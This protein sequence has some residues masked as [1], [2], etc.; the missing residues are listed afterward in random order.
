[1]LSQSQFLDS[2]VQVIRA[3][4]GERGIKGSTLGQLIRRALP[5]Q[6]WQACGFPTLKALLQELVK[7]QQVRIGNDDQGAFAVWL[8]AK[9]ADLSPQRQRY[10]PL[11]QDVWN[12]FAISY[13]SGRRFMHRTSGAV[14]MGQVER[15]TPADQW[16]EFEAIGDE[17]Q[18][19]WAREFVAELEGGNQFTEAV[20]AED[21]FRRFPRELRLSAIPDVGRK[22][23]RVRTERVSAHV[24][25]WCE[26]NKIDPELAFQQQASADLAFRPAS[27]SVP[28]ETRTV[29]LA[30]LARMTT[31][32]LL[33]IPIPAKYLLEEVTGSTPN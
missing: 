28:R 25:N 32:E 4:G 17:E 27:A 24:R 8:L 2:V 16:A 20:N 26:E 7:Q 11:R 23:N 18:R 3:N 31:D 14:R 30:A 5:D 9:P 33:Q 19:K 1:M 6:H 15:P 22:W 29:V 13:P 21:W 12:A 10:N